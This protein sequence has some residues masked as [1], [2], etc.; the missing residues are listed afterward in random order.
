MG[1]DNRATPTSHRRRAVLTLGMLAVTAV[2]ALGLAEIGLRVLA[3]PGITYQSYRYDPVTGG[4]LYPGSAVIYRDRNGRVVRRRVNSWGYLDARHRARKPAG[5]Y[6]IGFFGDSYVEARQVA[7]KET[8]FRLIETDLSH[9]LTSRTPL[10]RARGE[11]NRIET[12]AFG[13]AGRSAVQSYLDCRQRME[14][15]DLDCVVYVMFENDPRDQ[16]KAARR[17]NN[18]PYADV[19]GDSLVLDYSGRAFFAARNNWDHHLWLAVKAHSLV[20]STI[21]RRIKLLRQ[22]GIRMRPKREVPSIHPNTAPSTWRS[23]SL[24]TY[25]EKVQEQVMVDWRDYVR[26]RGR[27]FFVIYIPWEAEVR[28][29]TYAQDSWAPWV[30]DIC[31]LRSIHLIDPTSYFIEHMDAGENPFG[32]HLTPVGH[33]AVAEAF[34]TYFVEYANRR[35]VRKQTP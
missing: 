22:Y 24:L 1:P 7:L 35:Q 11:I 14:L 23:D 8:F 5:T 2:L 26:A 13:I 25:A 4:T 18:F 3:L 19:V 21:D 16:L 28:K 12:L 27:E 6:R 20:L 10:F 33:E 30:H 34:S 15:F 32:A 29:M 17:E 31:T 9:R